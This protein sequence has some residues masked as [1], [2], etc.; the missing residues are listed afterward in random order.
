[1]GNVPPLPA[2][3]SGPFNTIGLCAWGCKDGKV[4][5]AAAAA[6]VQQNST[7][8]VG[9]ECTTVFVI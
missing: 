7:E 2:D 4:G 8:L 6:A 9:V 5:A 1:M 3:F